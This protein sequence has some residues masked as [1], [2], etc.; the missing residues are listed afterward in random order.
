SPSDLSLITA[1]RRQRRT[2]RQDG[3]R[4]EHRDGEM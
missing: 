1:Y 3:R 4:Q 2:E